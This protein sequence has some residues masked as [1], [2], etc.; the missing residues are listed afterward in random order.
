[1]PQSNVTAEIQHTEEQANKSRMELQTV[2]DNSPALIY[3]KDK[4][5]HYVFVNRRWTERFDVSREAAT[6]KTDFELFPEE[7]ARQFVA[8]DRR[9]MES[10]H[11]LEFEEQSRLRDGMHSYQ[12][13]KVALRDEKGQ[14][15]AL[16]GISTDI[17][18]RKAKEES[19]RQTNRAIRMLSQ[20]SS[21]V[22]HASDEHALLNEVCRIAVGPAGYPMA[23]V[24]Y[25]DN[26]EN[27]TVSPVAFAGP[28]EGFLD[29]IHVSW[30][31]NQYGS[32]SMG[33]A[34]RTRK[35]AVVRRLFDQPTFAPWKEALKSRGLQSVLS[36][37]LCQRDSAFGAMAIYSQ[38]PEAFDSSEVDLFAELGENLAHGIVSL[39]ARKERDEATIALERAHRE[40]EERVRER[41]AELAKAKDRAESADR[42]KSAF[43]ASMSHE[44]RTPLNSI[45]GFTAIILQG[46]AGPL[47]DEQ[48]KQLGMVRNSARHLLDLINDI[49]DISKIEAGQLEIH[50]STFSMRES[51][52]KAVST[53]APLAQSKG[54]ELRTEISPEVNEVF[55][56]QRRTEQILLNLLGNAVKFTEQGQVAVKCMPEDEWFVVSVRDT[57][58]GIDVGD[59]QSI[60]EAFRQVD[61]GLGRKHEGTG[62]GLSICRRLAERIGGTIAVESALGKGSTFTLRLPLRS[63]AS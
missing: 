37:P 2:L 10:E 38:D 17:T 27:R 62:L 21:A 46:L 55:G 45:I 29:R 26:D 60:F 15:Y 56:D 53:V 36:L 39:R 40:L 50:C 6:G 7:S 47:N 59:Q 58:I 20:C 42:L 30:G 11:A 24:G 51:V 4:A 43:L 16:C 8:N 48:N 44:L 18:E 25:A 33:V 14:L 5:G 34:I 32:G 19:L 3:M 35:P 22:V 13:I 9:V 12:S 41:T 61:S 54:L 28:G 31:D 49:L 52:R 1:M 57:G 23:W 63:D